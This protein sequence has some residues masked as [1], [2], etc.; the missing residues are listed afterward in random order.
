MQLFT[1]GFEIWCNTGQYLLSF[2]FTS[3]DNHSSGTDFSSVTAPVRQMCCVPFCSH[4]NL[5][6]LSKPFTSLGAK[7]A[8]GH[9]SHTSYIPLSSSCYSYL[10][11]KC[12]AVLLLPPILI[13]I[14]IFL[15]FWEE[16]FFIF[17]WIPF[18][19]NE[20]WQNQIILK[21]IDAST[22]FWIWILF[23]IP[24]SKVCTIACSY[25]WTD[26]KMKNCIKYCH[27]LLLIRSSHG[28]MG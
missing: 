1:T 7:Q 26:N 24:P 17:Q 14:S 13:T 28:T 6:R 16:V 11:S 19:I 4:D 23:F 2:I 21:N 22:P 5:H 18:P 10:Y 9:A 12:C 27:I 3:L 15:L 8:Q 25:H 20:T